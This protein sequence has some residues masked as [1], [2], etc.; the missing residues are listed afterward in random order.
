MTD[1]V[2][3]V[4]IFITEQAL[5]SWCRSSS[6]SAREKD[7]ERGAPI[8]R[9][10]FINK[11]GYR[12]SVDA[13]RSRVVKSI[14]PSSLQDYGAERKGGGGS[15]RREKARKW[16]LIKC[17]FK[18]TQ[19]ASTSANNKEQ[20]HPWQRSSLPVDGWKLY[21][22]RYETVGSFTSWCHNNRL[23]DTVEMVLISRIIKKADETCA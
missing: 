15:R 20:C 22:M 4:K 12:L 9:L 2:Q 13:T 18:Q 1:S 3:N 5:L 6:L 16:I 11:D 21:S 17:V 23:F 8:C 10:T 19:L 7:E 14:W